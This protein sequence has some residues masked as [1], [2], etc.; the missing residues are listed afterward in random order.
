MTYTEIGQQQQTP[1]S[2]VFGGGSSVYAWDSQTLSK[3]LSGANVHSDVFYKVNT[4]CRDCIGT[5]ENNHWKKTSW[6]MGLLGNTYAAQ[7]HD[8]RGVTIAQS[9][10]SVS[11]T[12]GLD[13]VWPDLSAG[14]CGK[15]KHGFV[16]GRIY[17]PS[18]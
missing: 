7:G 10:I 12:S 16:F 11:D 13:Y 17:G 8:G 6:S 5:W 3:Q 18:N 4:E 14:R 9:S 15:C 1:N 2:N